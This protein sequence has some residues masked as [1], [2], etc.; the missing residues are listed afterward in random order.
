[1]SSRETHLEVSMSES[2]LLGK[3]DKPI[4]KSKVLESLIPKRQSKI[5]TPWT[6]TTLP[7]P[8]L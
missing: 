2:V 3:I 4:L 1:M 8:N 7:P 6:N 5:I